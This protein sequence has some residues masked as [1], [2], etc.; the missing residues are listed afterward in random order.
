MKQPTVKCIAA[1]W[2]SFCWHQR[3]VEKVEKRHRLLS[4]AMVPDGPAGCS[5]SG[6]S[7]LAAQ[8]LD[9]ARWQL[10]LA[11]LMQP[12]PLLLCSC[13]SSDVY[14]GSNK[15]RLNMPVGQNILKCILIHNILCSHILGPHFFTVGIGACLQY[16]EENWREQRSLVW[17]RHLDRALSGYLDQAEVSKL[18]QADRLQFLIT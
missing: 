12:Q 6:Q 14:S 8:V 13:I 18:V 3:A 2:F 17:E 9:G 11:G 16:N 4:A 7:P 1:E 5:G 10:C 15:I